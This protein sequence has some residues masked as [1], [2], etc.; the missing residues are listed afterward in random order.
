LESSEATIRG[1]SL[2]RGGMLV[3]IG[4]NFEGFDM[5]EVPNEIPEK[6]ETTCEISGKR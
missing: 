5:E 4:G 6:E 3:I 2:I 1:D